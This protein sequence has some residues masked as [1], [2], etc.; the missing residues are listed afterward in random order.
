VFEPIIAGTLFCIWRWQ[1][2]WFL[3]SKIIGLGAIGSEEGLSRL[4]ALF[5]F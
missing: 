5:F 3:F 1:Q 4:S 2:G